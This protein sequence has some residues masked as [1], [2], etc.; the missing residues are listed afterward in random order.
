MK[1]FVD[2]EKKYVT[3]TESVTYENGILKQ[4]LLYKY[5]LI[6]MVPVNGNAMDKKICEIRSNN[7]FEGSTD[8]INYQLGIPVP[9]SKIN[10]IAKKCNIDIAFLIHEFRVLTESLKEDKGFLDKDGN[11]LVE[12]LIDYVVQRLISEYLL[13]DKN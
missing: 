10:E 6:S 11:L 2:K 1:V 4:G 3:L 7:Y 13:H 12:D 5:H 9:F 8:R